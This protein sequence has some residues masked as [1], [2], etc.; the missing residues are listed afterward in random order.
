[1]LIKSP[2]RLK[3]VLKEN[4]NQKWDFFKDFFHNKIYYTKYILEL[5]NEKDLLNN[6]L[7]I[8]KYG[9]FKGYQNQKYLVLKNEK[10]FLK[11]YMNYVY[12]IKKDT[13]Q[14]IKSLYEAFV[15]EYKI[16][17]EEKKV[18]YK[19]HKDA[20]KTKKALKLFKNTLIDIRMEKINIIFKDLFSNF[21][22]NIYFEKF[23]YT[24]LSKK[25]YSYKSILIKNFTNIG[26]FLKETDFFDMLVSSKQIS[27]TNLLS[28]IFGVGIS[29]KSNKVLIDKKL[30][31]TTNIDL[32]KAA[33]IIYINS[34]IHRNILIKYLKENIKEEISLSRYFEYIINTLKKTLP[35][36][37][38]SSGLPLYNNFY[39][40]LEKDKFKF[41]KKILEAVIP[42]LQVL[43]SNVKIEIKVKDK[44]IKIEHLS[45][46]KIYNSKN[47]YLFDITKK[48]LSTLDNLY[49]EVKFFKDTIYYNFILDNVNQF[50][51]EN[52][53][54]IK[55]FVKIVNYNK[56][57]LLLFKNFTNLDIK[58]KEF[59]KIIKKRRT[60][61]AFLKIN[62]DELNKLTNSNLYIKKNFIAY[63]LD[64]DKY[65]Y[66]VNIIEKRS[67]NHLNKVLYFL[68]NKE[69]LIERIKELVTQIKKYED[70]DEKKLLYKYINSE[71]ENRIEYIFDIELSIYLDTLKETEKSNE[72]KIQYEHSIKKHYDNF[73]QK[74]NNIKKVSYYF[75]PTNSGKTY[76]A[77]NEVVKY[78]NG[79]YL[80]PLRLLA[81]EGKTEIQKRGRPC[82][83]ITGEEKEI[84]KGANFTSCT[85][86]TI[87]LN[88]QYD[89]VII[90]EIQMIMNRER[91]IYWIQSLLKIKCN[92]LILVGNES[93]K[94]IITKFLNNKVEMVK[95]E[96]KNKLLFQGDITLSKIEKGAAIITFSRSEVFNIKKT[97]EEEY[98]KKVAIIYGNLP[99]A[100]KIN[101]ARKFSSSDRILISTDAIGM[102]LNLP[103]K[104]I[105]FSEMEKYDGNEIRELEVEEIK[106][107][108]GRAGRYGHSN[109]VGGVYIL[110]EEEAFINSGKNEINDIL[111]RNDIFDSNELIYIQPSFE[112]INRYSQIFS[113][114]YIHNI[115]LNIQHIINLEEYHAIYHIPKKYFDIAKLIDAHTFNIK[116]KYKILTIPVDVNYFNK[117]AFQSLLLSVFNKEQI[118]INEL[119]DIEKIKVLLKLSDI[120]D[121]EEIENTLNSISVIKWFCNNY[122]YI[123]EDKK[124][125]ETIENN[126]ILLIMSILNK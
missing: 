69:N 50:L 68:S 12:S 29:Y 126:L 49:E 96:R 102:G 87:D 48:T 89:A 15:K 121:L 8:L 123:L 105:I 40:Y 30:I 95:H 18:I 112:D 14:Q 83:L 125:L 39:L 59:I 72:K 108:A 43:K 11:E 124:E 10:E 5:K 63:K 62:I 88:R 74:N 103:I 52:I 44:N 97:L 47:T 122:R 36:W 110:S 21:D 51:I 9:N 55:T 66:I 90:D 78:N 77:F 93:V 2:N 73:F 46:D 120:E 25:T 45:L 27:M 6:K 71:V 104:N 53:F 41:Q 81:V 35:K 94:H 80:A 70:E 98:H 56:N 57:Y 1:M 61:N 76:N 100:V 38:I 7:S 24:F 54:S 32:E 67:A 84:E 109:E 16:T 118:D 26:G 75:G 64:V 115:L 17:T 58:E 107:I 85:I 65:K 42:T 60:I 3:E 116:E 4:D 92:H 13:K 86:E 91:G 28:N 34:S 106:Q 22:N 23:L 113:D 37:V 119:L 31:K 79:V 99:P 114:K 117:A 101:E 82:N 19:K 20:N 111:E 33:N